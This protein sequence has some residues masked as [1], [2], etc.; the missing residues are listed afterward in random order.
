MKEMVKEKQFISPRMS[1][2]LREESASD[3]IKASLSDL[4]STGVNKGWTFRL[5][6]TTAM[7]FEIKEITG[8]KPP[9]DWLS[10]AK[11]LGEMA[12]PSGKKAGELAAGVCS[13]DAPYFNWADYHDVTPIRDQGNCGSCWDFGTLG[14]FEGSWAIINGVQINCSEQDVLDCSG[15]GS[16]AGGWWAYQYLIDKGVADA[17]DYPYT[18]AQG[19]CNLNV[20]RPYK[21]SVWGYVDNNNEIPTV[22]AIKA[23]LCQYGPL[24]ITVAVTPAFQ[25]YTG[26]V[27]NEGS[28]AS[29][30]HAITLVGWNDALQAWRIKNSWGTGWGEC[31]FMWIAYGTNSVGYGAS[32]VQAVQTLPPC[33]PLPHKICPPA[34]LNICPPKPKF[35]QTPT[36]KAGFEP[37]EKAPKAG[38]K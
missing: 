33:P 20:K 21:A 19:T 4:R 5:G 3:E 14:A 6:Y 27:F 35:P 29:I 22:A 23:A 32:W 18:A 9:S 36:S 17:A 38:K 31:G 7:D 24:G 12:K 16:C 8:M 15:A 2:H 25:A 26:G 1:Y 10:K 11:Q 28:T 37:E 13:A 34:P 30:N